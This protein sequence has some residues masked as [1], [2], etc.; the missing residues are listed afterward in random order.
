MHCEVNPQHRE[1]SRLR[2]LRVVRI[3]TH[4]ELMRKGFGS[5]AL[6]KLCEEA[7]EKGYDWVGASFEAN[8]SL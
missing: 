3:A 2:G 7:V 1:F 4:P 5:L 8:A 6:T